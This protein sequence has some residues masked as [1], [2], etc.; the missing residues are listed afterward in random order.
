MTGMMVAQGVGGLV[1]AIGGNSAAK[2][3]AA[4]TR[5]AMRIQQQ[6]YNQSRADQQPWRQA[7]QVGLSSLMDGMGFSSTTNAAGTKCA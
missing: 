7:G 4:A 3:Q 6:M 5:D 1:S 2:K